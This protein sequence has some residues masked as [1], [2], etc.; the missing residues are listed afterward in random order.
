VGGGR[1]VGALLDL[2]ETDVVDDQ[3]VGAGPALEPAR[4]G[5]VG[6][7]G[8]EVVEQVD[9]AGVAHADALLA[10]AQPEG[11][12]DVALAGPVGAGDH[13]VVVPVHEVEPGEL[14]HEVLVE[15]GLEGPVEGLE[16]LAL[17]EAALVDAP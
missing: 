5:A 4:V 10:G 11:L 3:E 6:E 13:E 16:R 9:A 8:V 14:E 7:A 1:F 17:D 2:A 12:E 15:A